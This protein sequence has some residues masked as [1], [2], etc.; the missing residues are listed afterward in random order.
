MCKEEVV[1]IG[2]G[3]GGALVRSWLALY[4]TL[5]I[6]GPFLCYGLECMFHAF[7]LF[8]GFLH[9]SALSDPFAGVTSFSP[10]VWKA[11]CWYDGQHTE[12]PP[13]QMC[14]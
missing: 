14:M 2:G 6:E 10:F 13:E 8:T 11:H 7:A 9:R 1:A 3:G 4:Q 12:V 5:R